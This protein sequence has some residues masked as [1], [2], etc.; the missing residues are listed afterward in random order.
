MSAETEREVHAPTA[1]GAHSG[2]S[3]H[4]APVPGLVAATDMIQRAGLLRSSLEHTLESCWHAVRRSQSLRGELTV[5]QIR[6]YVLR[7]RFHWD[8][9]SGLVAALQAATRAPDWRAG[10]ELVPGQVRLLPER[11]SVELASGRRHV[12]TR[13][14]WQ[15]L[16]AFLARPGQIVTRQELASY[17]WG[18][19]S[20]DRSS[21]V[22]VYI[23]RLRRKIEANPQKPRIIETV[24][25]VG[26][27]LN[28]GVLP[29]AGGYAPNGDGHASA[30][31]PSPAPAG[32][33]GQSAVDD[34][35][36]PR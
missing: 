9:Y 36:I 13:T 23:S 28:T 15:L 3:P 29:K 32:D 14:E 5:E 34:S 16:A 25:G 33:D 27:R 8:L 10:Q 7:A 4:P 12:L 26:Y 24:R 20:I 22:E 35:S 6:S 18:N 1:D 30:P 31:K 2:A 19:K 11:Q 17:A 21:E